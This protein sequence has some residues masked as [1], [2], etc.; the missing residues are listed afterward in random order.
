MHTRDRFGF[1]DPPPLS[2][3]LSHVSQRMICVRIIMMKEA[4]KFEVH[5]KHEKIRVSESL[6]SKGGE[7]VY[8]LYMC[9]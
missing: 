3:V 9:E 7:H 4:W 6:C 8:E 2:P 1:G 5:V